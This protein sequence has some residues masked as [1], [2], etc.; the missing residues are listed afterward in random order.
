MSILDF[1]NVIRV[2]QGLRITGV[3]EEY[4]IQKEV[5]KVL[6]LHN[7]KFEKEYT[8][9]PRNRIDFFLDNGIGIEVKKG[10]PNK[11]KV[12]SQLERYAKFN[13]ITALILIIERS[14]DV[15]VIINNKPCFSIGLNK[16]WGI[17]L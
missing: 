11:V 15:P 14:M 9:G 4:E 2:L 13:K 16:Q 5:A 3:Y 17:A 1:Q 6:G 12:I 10:K 7:I 8:L